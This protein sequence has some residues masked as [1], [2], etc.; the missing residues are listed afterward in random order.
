MGIVLIVAALIAAAAALAA[1]VAAAVAVTG[2]V[3]TATTACSTVHARGPALLLLAGY[4]HRIVSRAN[5]FELWRD[6]TRRR[7]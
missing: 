1:A 5:A 2:I 4:D 3:S 7:G 6:G